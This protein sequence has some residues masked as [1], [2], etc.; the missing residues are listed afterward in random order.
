MYHGDILVSKLATYF[1]FI[2]IFISCLGLFGLAA[3][4]AEKRV[5]EVGI[6]KV[7]GA[8]VPH[9]VA[10]L[11][12]DFLKLVLIANIIAWPLAWWAMSNWLENFEYRTPIE[13]W[14][15]GTGRC[16]RFTDCLTYSKLPVY[17]SRYSQSGEEFKK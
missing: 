15:L 8:S 13:W 3:Y 7:L 12:K 5:K 6:R 17:K 2:T 4:T 11:S 1:A 16:S 10:M 9:I 14:V